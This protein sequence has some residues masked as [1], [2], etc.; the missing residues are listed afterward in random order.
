MKTL[1]A[2]VRPLVITLIAGSFLASCMQAQ[3]QQSTEGL[4]MQAARAKMMTVRGK[5]ISYTKKFD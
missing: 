4:D 3:A 2:T 5:K 1:R